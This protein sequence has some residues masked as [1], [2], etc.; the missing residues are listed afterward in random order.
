MRKRMEQRRKKVVTTLKKAQSSLDRIVGEMTRAD[1][2]DACFAM[3]QQNLAVIGLLKSA[4]RAMLENHVD[5][6][7]EQMT[8]LSPKDKRAIYALRDEVLRVVHTAQSK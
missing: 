2:D 8:D 1:N 4:N 5:R 7:L 6:T 3:I